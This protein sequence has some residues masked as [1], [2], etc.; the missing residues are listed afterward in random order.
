MKIKRIHE[1]ELNEGFVSSLFS[2]IGNLFKSKK[3]KIESILKD[4]KKAREEDINNI[5]SIEKEIWNL[6]KDN[7]PEYRFD[8][9]N[10][11]RQIRTYSSLKGQEIDSLVKQ[12]NK[13]IDNDPKLQAFFSASLAKIEAEVTERMIR[14]I[15]PYKEKTYLDKLNQEFED[16]VKDATKKY[17]FYEDYE[18]KSSPVESIDFSEKISRD[19]AKFMELPS[20]ESS[21]YLI[22]L[23]GGELTKM[24]NE[25]K[26]VSFDLD[27]RYRKYIDSIKKDR[28]KAMEQGQSHLIPNLEQEEIRI[29]YEFG[30]PIEKIRS[31]IA[32]I[33]KEKKSRKYATAQ[34]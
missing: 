23:D 27:V 12:A 11:N 16:L 22:G 26:E 28:K 2:G 33:E 18:K 10:L 8:V 32:M 24:Y 5:I 3:S 29:R 34:A 7:S 25:L 15:K 4:I 14:G 31:R 20:R 19:T 6:P 17:S 9:T 30:K 13:I 21:T 1:F